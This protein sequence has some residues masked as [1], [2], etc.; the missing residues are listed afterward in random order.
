MHERLHLGQLDDKA[1]HVMGRTAPWACWSISPFQGQQ[2]VLHASSSSNPWSQ[3]WT[4]SYSFPWPVQWVVLNA[5]YGLSWLSHCRWG[6]DGIC[7]QVSRWALSHICA[8]T[9][10]ISLPNP[11]GATSCNIY[12]LPWT[13]TFPFPSHTSF[14]FSAFH[15][16]SGWHA[17]GRLWPS[18]SITHGAVLLG[19]VQ[20]LFKDSSLPCVWHCLSCH[21]LFREP[22]QTNNGPECGWSPPEDLLPSMP[23][24]GK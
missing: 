19:H 10:R 3:H 21:L 23:Q 14:Q 12:M 24:P 22:S 11:N 15:S 5:A 4:H 7:S 8:H 9:C 18:I 2:S 13:S 17:Q 6:V 16:A 20:T 1:V